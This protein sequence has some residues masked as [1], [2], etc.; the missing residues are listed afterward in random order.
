MYRRILLPS[1]SGLRFFGLF[2]SFGF[3]SFSTRPNYVSQFQKLLLCVRVHLYHLIFLGNHFIRDHVWGFAWSEFI[4]LSRKCPNCIFNGDYIKVLVVLFEKTLK[5]REVIL[6]HNIYSKNR[7]YGKIW[8]WQK[9]CCFLLTCR[10]VRQCFV[11]RY[12]FQL[13]IHFT[14]LVAFFAWC[15]STL[16]WSR[17]H[18]IIQNCEIFWKCT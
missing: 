16:L 9:T 11:L 13:F 12:K 14:T 2:W 7:V 6:V 8:H 5:S 1:S 18:V 3:C 17:E 15:S 10:S 4:I